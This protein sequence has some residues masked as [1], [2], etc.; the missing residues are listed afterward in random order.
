LELVDITNWLDKRKLRYSLDQQ[1]EN[2]TVIVVQ[3]RQR[4]DFKTFK[5]TIYKAERELELL[6]VSS[7]DSSYRSQFRIRT[8]FSFYKDV[9]KNLE[10]EIGSGV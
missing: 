6:D 10:Q 1:D 2:K 5:L 3:V 7:L 8:R 9:L 4:I